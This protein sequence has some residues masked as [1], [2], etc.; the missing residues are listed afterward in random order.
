MFATIRRHSR[1]T[2]SLIEIW[3]GFYLLINS[4]L[5]LLSGVHSQRRPGQSDVQYFLNGTGIGTSGFWIR[6]IA[7]G[8]GGAMI[9]LPFLG[10][11][12]RVVSLRARLDYTAFVLFTYVGVLVTIYV[13]V[14]YYLWIAPL[15]SGLLCA[16]AYLG[17]K[18]ELRLLLLLRGGDRGA[19]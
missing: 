7:V 12:P 8:V 5:P 10:N 3:L 9:A 13:P 4:L 17:N 6:V 16:S 15:A 18:A 1:F 19:G 2:L 11:S 14:D